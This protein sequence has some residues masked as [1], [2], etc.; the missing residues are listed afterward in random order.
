MREGLYIYIFIFNG[1]MLCYW[2]CARER[3]HCGCAGP[4]AIAE[5]NDDGYKI[6]S[7]QSRSFGIKSEEEEENK[8]TYSMLR[9]K[10]KCR[11]I[12]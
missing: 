12:S 3:V 4:A 6:V 10:K 7:E 2:L 8:S 11:K 9:N 5:L 1:D